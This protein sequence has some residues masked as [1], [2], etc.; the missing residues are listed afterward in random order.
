MLENLYTTKMS[1]DKKKL[2]NRFAKIRSKS[3]RISKLMAFVIFAIILLIIVCITIAIAARVNH[4]DY[5]MTENEFS[6]Y[7][8]APVGAVMADIYYA[9]NSKIV[10]HYGEGFFIIHN[11]NPNL[12]QNLRSELDIMINLKKLNIAYGQQGDSVLDVKISRDG[13]FAY[14]SSVGPDDIVKDYDKYI[15]SLDNGGVKKGSMPKNTELF[16]G[17]GD[18]FSAVQNPVGWYSDNCIVSEDKTYYLTSTTGTVNDIQLISVNNKNNEIDVKYLFSGNSAGEMQQIK[19]YTP[20][21]IRDLANVELVIK[22]IKYPLVNKDA[23]KEIEKAFSTA[24]K[25]KMGGTGCPL[26]AELLF[27]RKDGEKGKVFIAT[28]S[29]DVFLS[30]VYYD[31]GNDDNSALL[32]YFGLDADSFYD[33]LYNGKSYIENSEMALQNFFNA[34][35]KSDLET[36]KTLVTNDFINAG[37]IGDYGMCYGMTRATLEIFSGANVDEF[38]KN[39]FSK[40]K[41]EQIELSENDIKLLKEKSDELVVYTV[42]VTAESNIKGNIKPPFRRFL[43]VIC[44]K[45]DNGRYLVHKLV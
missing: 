20:D 15:V 29:C 44:K 36:M 3:G 32:G 25:I 28:D 16:T 45:Q 30:N 31:Y 13:S 24:T 40:Q 43:N 26:G 1:M 21:D 8:N 5:T 6:D 42:V 17:I 14:L 4:D 12:D 41:H 27:T 23:L 10:F 19:I 37:Y 34:F 9:D 11:Q 39:Y 18:T 7:V 35:D 2:Q 22:N 38:L 33:I